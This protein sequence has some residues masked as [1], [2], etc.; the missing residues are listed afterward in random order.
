MK[1][2]R[3]DVHQVVLIHK[4]SKLVDVLLEGTHLL[5][6]GT[7]ATIYNTCDPV[8]IGSVLEPIINDPRLTD[9]LTVV[10][11]A[12]DEIGIEMR[13]GLFKR[14]VYPGKRGY[15]D[16]P[17]K[18][19]VIKIDLSKPHIDQAIPKTVVMHASMQ[20]YRLVY[21][22]ES[23]QKGLLFINGVYQKQLGPGV[24]YYWKAPDLASVVTVD[25]RMQSLEI[26]G[27]EILTKDKVAIRVNFQ[28]QYKISDVEKAI[29]ESKD[30]QKQL[31]IML[32]I[33]MREYVGSLT[34]DDL[35]TN[36]SK[37]GAYI[38]SECQSDAKTLGL[39]II[40]GGIKDIILPGDVKD[41]MNQVLIAQKKAQANTIMRQEETASTRS[42]L[43]TAKMMEDNTMLLKLKEMEYME[44]IALK[45]GDISINGKGRV[46]DQ[47][48]DLL[49]T[50]KA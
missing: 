12:D 44:K 21:V 19:D 31:Y 42:L 7:T 50:A 8:I 37:V 30:Y 40:S 43:N 26:L 38:L 15:F 20:S 25:M 47:L 22:V 4:R 18:Y 28:S 23:Y 48:N 29:C 9:I 16:G 39:D 14:I 13:E 35:L 34:I 46:M 33:A 10:E 27:Q 5:G 2:I 45:I 6:F 36:K 11:V 3:V 17:I 49:S 1:L 41:I 32:Q 24:Y